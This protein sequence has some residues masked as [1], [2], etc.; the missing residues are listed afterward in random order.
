MG[1]QDSMRRFV[2]GMIITGLLLGGSGI[3]LAAATDTDIGYQACNEALC[4][5]GSGLSGTRVIKN[6][7]QSVLDSMVSAGTINSEQEEIILAKIDERSNG[8]NNFGKKPENNTRTGNKTNQ[9]QSWPGQID[10]WEQ[11][12]QDGIVNQEQADAIK[13]KI[14][15]QMADLRKERLNTA[16]NGLVEQEIINDDQAAAVLKKLTDK[17]IE[18]QESKE[19]FKHMT[20]EQRQGAYLY[21]IKPREN[22]LLNELVAAG[23][24]SQTQADQIIKAIYFAGYEI[25]P[26][27]GYRWGLAK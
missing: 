23:T 18:R 19:Q 1:N 10:L 3:A 17:P 26:D 21:S 13:T 15:D 16:L 20:A 25:R 27:N 2:G 7:I 24:L 9:E 11:M 12:V 4:V 8:S 22:N 14:R 6:A 5:Q